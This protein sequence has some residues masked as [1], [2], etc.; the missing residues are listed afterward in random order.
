MNFPG[1]I[2][3]LVM[4][5]RRH[6]QAHQLPQVAFRTSASPSRQE[7]PSTDSDERDISVRTLSRQTMLSFTSKFHISVLSPVR[8]VFLGSIHKIFSQIRGLLQLFAFL[9]ESLPKGT[10][11]LFWSFERLGKYICFIKR[12]KKISFG[13]RLRRQAGCSCHLNKKYPCFSF[14]FSFRV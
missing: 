13:W 9:T 3:I 7:L 10:P 1:R 4:I 5:E 8:P 11:I 14:S 2:Q 12:K 6:R